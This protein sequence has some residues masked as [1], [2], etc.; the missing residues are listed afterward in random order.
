MYQ[1][2]RLI[3]FK[4]KDFD[5]Y[6]EI[7]ENFYSEKY[8]REINQNLDNF[9]NKEGDLEG[10]KIIEN[11]FR[12]EKF[13]IFLSHSHKD[14]DLALGIAGFLNKE[15]K[16][17]VFIDSQ[18][19]GYVDELL[20]KIDNKYCYQKNTETYNYQKRNISTAHVHLMLNN[21][22]TKMIDCC[23]FFFFLDSPNSL[24]YS[25]SIYTNNKED[26]TYSPWINS[27]IEIT[28]VIRRND[29]LEGII[30]EKAQEFAQ[31][32]LQIAYKPN[33]KDFID[34]DV[35]EIKDNAFLK[36]YI[37]KRNKKNNRGDGYY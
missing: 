21:A 12:E 18:V 28:N 33:F 10:N 22:L 15:F 17:K 29:I 31:E 23:Y 16:L 36:D 35:K 2:F 20:K 34:L 3:N 37:L 14:K 4:M 13:D 27:E 19:W 6:T 30:D 24:K 7:G 5:S 1:K 11:W 26:I 32:S 8:K 9:L 25:P